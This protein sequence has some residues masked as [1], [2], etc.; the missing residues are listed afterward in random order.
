ME[1]QNF[2]SL[3]KKFAPVQDLTFEGNDEMKTLTSRVRNDYITF[4]YCIASCNFFLKNGDN[5]IPAE[6]G[7]VKYSMSKGIVGQYHSLIDPAETIPM[8]KSQFCFVFT[9][10]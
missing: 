4:P 1:N 6:V 9:F 8:R 7:M 5:C 3:S 10:D 2:L